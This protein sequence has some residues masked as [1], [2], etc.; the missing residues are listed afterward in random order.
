M[1]KF[2]TW[3]LKCILGYAAVLTPVFAIFSA[4]LKISIT[5]LVVP[6]LLLLIPAA[7]GGLIMWVAVN[8]F[9][10]PKSYSLLLSLTVF[11]VFSFWVF[12]I[13]RFGL[14]LGFFKQQFSIVFLCIGLIGA[15][16]SCRHVFSLTYRRLSGDWPRH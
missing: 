3:M 10:R 15:I 5:E 7:L 14:K 9:N 13:A 16:F 8:C 11:F 6:Y 2:V 4:A 12:T 1:L